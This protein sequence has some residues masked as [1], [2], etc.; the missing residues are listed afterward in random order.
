MGRHRGHLLQVST[1]GPSHHEDDQPYQTPHQ[2]SVDADVLQILADLK[3]QPTCP[4]TVRV[5][6]C[7]SNQSP[8]RRSALTILGFIRTA[9]W[10]KPCK[11]TVGWTRASFVIVLIFFSQLRPDR[12]FRRNDGF[13]SA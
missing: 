4:R 2:G 7:A 3:L 10:N 11:L 6:R 1:K 13:R 8:S 9:L 12:N 5:N